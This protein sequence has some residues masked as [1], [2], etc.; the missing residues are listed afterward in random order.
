MA[1]T[2]PQR[3]SGVCLIAI[4]VRGKVKG[5]VWGP[6][7]QASS[8]I[9]LYNDS[10]K[11]KGGSVQVGIRRGKERKQEKMKEIK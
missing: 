8:F 1:R 3:D 7:C 10:R 6:G 11:G 4:I 2:Y 9:D 5:V